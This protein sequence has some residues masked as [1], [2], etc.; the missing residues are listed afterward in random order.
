MK[1]YQIQNEDCDILQEAINRYKYIIRRMLKRAQYA[2]HTTYD[3]NLIEHPHPEYRNNPY[4]I[5][6]MD[7]ITIDLKNPCEIQPHPH[8]TEDCE[9]SKYSKRTNVIDIL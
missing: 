7:E 9:Y 2:K 4:F 8:M 6:Y 1:S 5:G 3:P